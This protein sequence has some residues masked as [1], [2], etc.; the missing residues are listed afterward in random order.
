MRQLTFKKIYLKY[1]ILSVLLFFVSVVLG[2]LL[3]DLFV[4]I[5]GVLVAAILLIPIRSFWKIEKSGAYSFKNGEIVNVEMRIKT[6][7]FVPPTVSKIL[8]IQKEIVLEVEFE[9][10]DGLRLIVPQMDYALFY[11]DQIFE[12]ASIRVYYTMDDNLLCLDILPE[13]EAKSQ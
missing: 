6:S 10:S 3:S 1:V 9:D 12:G 8:R 11:H 2:F 4:F 5:I 13:V 7:R